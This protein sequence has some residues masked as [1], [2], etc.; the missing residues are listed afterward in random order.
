MLKLYDMWQSCVEIE[1]YFVMYFDRIAVFEAP[2]CW[3]SVKGEAHMCFVDSLDIHASTKHI[4]ALPRS[5]AI[6]HFK[7][8][9]VI[10]I[11][12]GIT[13]D[14]YMGLPHMQLLWSF[15]IQSLWT[16]LKNMASNKYCF[17]LRWTYVNYYQ[18]PGSNTNYLNHYSHFDTCMVL[19]TE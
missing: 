11:C 18:S 16:A 1:G 4:W 8:S 10:K 7:H 17:T 15:I 12:N 9:N 5:S 14:F 19:N 13:I 2:Y 3:T 6:Q